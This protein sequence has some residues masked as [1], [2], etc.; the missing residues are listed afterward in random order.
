MSGFEFE[1]R[2]CPACG[3]PFSA[4]TFWDEDSKCGDCAQRDYDVRLVEINQG[5]P[6]TVSSIGGA[7]P[8]QAEG[9]WVNGH[10]YYFRARHGDWQLR[11]AEESDG[12]AV[13]GKWIAGGDDPSGGWMEDEAVLAILDTAAAS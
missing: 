3:T 8:T 10:P 1:D 2:N 13:V 4:L 5:R 7:C 11:V 12:D 9:L 6:Y